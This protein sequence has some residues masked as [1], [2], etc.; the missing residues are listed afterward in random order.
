MGERFGLRMGH[1]LMANNA[2]DG[3]SCDV[4]V[5]AWSG[6]GLQALDGVNDDDNEARGNR[7]MSDRRRIVF[8]VVRDDKSGLIRQ[9]AQA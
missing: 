5:L 1:S 9:C 3:R 8:S 7:Q 6:E 4:A 2:G